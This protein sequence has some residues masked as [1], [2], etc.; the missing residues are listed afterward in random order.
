MKREFFDYFDKKMEKN[1]KI[2][3]LFGDL[4]WPRTDEFLE[5][6]PDR[7]FNMGASEQ[8][9]LDVAVGLALSGKIPVCYTISPFYY[10]AFETLRTYINHEKLNVKMVAV[11]QDKDYKHDGFSHHATDL[12]NIMRP[13]KNITLIQ[14]PNTRYFEDLIDHML[15]VKD[16]VMLNL[17]R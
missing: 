2:F 5:K 15:K 6:Y 16:P 14:P 8:T 7:V 9:M 3:L 4:G 17:K 1:P 11:G 12:R 10:R 13:L